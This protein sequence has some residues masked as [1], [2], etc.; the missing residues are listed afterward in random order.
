M[1]TPAYSIQPRREGG[2]ELD[3]RVESND[4]VDSG[5]SGIYGLG[6]GVSAGQLRVEVRRPPNHRQTVSFSQPRGG[7]SAEPSKEL[8]LRRCLIS[9]LFRLP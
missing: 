1:S 8:D 4:I 3:E 6:L 9:T 2:R 5:F 7:A